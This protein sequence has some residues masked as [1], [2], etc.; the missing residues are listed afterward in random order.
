MFDEQKPNSGSLGKGLGIGVALNL[1]ALVITN[2]E[3]SARI[4]FTLAKVAGALFF[5]IGAVQAFWMIPTS[6]ILRRKARPILREEFSPASSGADL[7]SS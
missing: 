1:A 3:L 2:P 7:H 4:S 6:L 5:S